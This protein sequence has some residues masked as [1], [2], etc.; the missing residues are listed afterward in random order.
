MNVIIKLFFFFTIC[1][2][3]EE[4]EYKYYIEWKKVSEN[5]EYFLELKNSENQIIKK[6]KV[7]NNFYEFNLKPGNYFYRIA[8]LNKFSKPSTFSN[9]GEI[10]IEK[11]K[12]KKEKKFLLTLV[13]GLV[14]F[15]S[16]KKNYSYFWWSY[17]F[18]LGIIGNEFRLKGNQIANEKLNDPF[19]LSALNWNTPILFDFYFL[20]RL[21]AE[22]KEYD[23]YQN[24]Q[25]QISVLALV[26]Y[27]VQIY[28][29]RKIQNLEF[30][31]TTEKKMSNLNQMESNTEIYF[32]W[33]F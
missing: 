32:V 5:S 21:D 17:F 24:R 15:K 22:K 8:L 26:S 1:I 31:F 12:Q 25:K 10:K 18:T 14:Q 33:R 7:K 19:F 6:E 28:Q 16:D 2:F 23:L 13:P 11:E 29:A 27:F 20:N 4:K 30:N 9:W 3:S